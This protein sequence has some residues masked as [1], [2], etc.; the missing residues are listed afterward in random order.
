M[1]KEKIHGR[2]SAELEKAHRVLDTEVRSLGG[3]QM[4]LNNSTWQEQIL[5]SL[6]TTEPRSTLDISKH[7]SEE[8]DGYTLAQYLKTLLAKGLVQKAGFA[9]GDFQLW[10]RASDSEG[11]PDD[12]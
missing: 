11:G 1:N 10:I 5:P 9:Q 4:P 12:R 6:S 2:L 3:R 8:V 7:L